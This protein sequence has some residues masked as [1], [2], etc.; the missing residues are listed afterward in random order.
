MTTVTATTWCIAH[1]I[2]ALQ[3]D[4]R[5]D[6]TKP[7]HEPRFLSRLCKHRPGLSR[8]G[9]PVSPMRI[10]VVSPVRAVAEAICRALGELIGEEVHAA[11]AN[12]PR[13]L[14]PHS[15]EAAVVV[16]DASLISH[17]TS[18]NT[19]EPDFGGAHL[20]VFGVGSGVRDLCFCRSWNVEGLV[21]EGASLDELVEA[22]KEVASGHFFIAPSA[23]RLIRS[24]ALD[25]LRDRRRVLLT[26]RE[27]EVATL[28]SFG[29]SNF[30][31]ASQ[32]GISIETARIHV[33][34][35]LRKLE[36]VTRDGIVKRYRSY[37]A[38]EYE[39]NGALPQAQSPM[40]Q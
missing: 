2:H 28:I 5:A 7:F 21:G 40:H 18:L 11:V 1:V 16:V 33:K 31:I 14:L 13:D 22:T 3:F 9:A 20:L 37:V 32:L 6:V 15:R 17:A 24:A 39:S 25:G 12:S 30:S 26:R 8:S 4:D 35:L 23:A 38:E 27:Q 10:V 34:H 19:K 36:A 29:G